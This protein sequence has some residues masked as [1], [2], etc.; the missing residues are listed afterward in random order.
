MSRFLDEFLVALLFL[1]VFLVSN[2]AAIASDSVT[3]AQLATHADGRET[4]I[5][6]AISETDNESVRQM[7]ESSEW[8]EEHESNGPEGSLGIPMRQLSG[9][10]VAGLIIVLVATAAVSLLSANSTEQRK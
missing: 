6:H 1:T 10:R 8:E 5:T 3:S 7:S 2:A 4:N 9:W